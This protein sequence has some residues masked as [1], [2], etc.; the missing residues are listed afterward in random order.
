M[1]QDVQCQLS[2]M[3]RLLLQSLAAL[4]WSA[5]QSRHM[6]GVQR[7]HQELHQNKREEYYIFYKQITCLFEAKQ[8]LFSISNK[9]I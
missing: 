5:A 4:I 1:R 8:T 9:Q 2:L 6:S 3:G 7:L